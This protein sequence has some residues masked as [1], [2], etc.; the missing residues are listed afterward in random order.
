MDLLWPGSV[1]RRPVAL[2]EGEHGECFYLCFSPLPFPVLQGIANVL[3]QKP[4]LCPSPAGLLGSSPREM[5]LEEVHPAKY[6]FY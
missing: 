6:L 2:A 1:V 5:V 4:S 3:R